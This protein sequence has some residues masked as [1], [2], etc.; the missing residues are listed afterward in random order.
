MISIATIAAA[1]LTLNPHA[2]DR[3]ADRIGSAIVAV[4]GDDLD[5]I[6]ALLVNGKAES[7][8]EADKGSCLVEGLGGLGFWGL[9]KGWGRREDRCGTVERQARIAIDAVANVSD[10]PA[11]HFAGYLARPVQDREVRVRT[12]LFWTVRARVELAACL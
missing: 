1:L 10:D 5:K 9:A 7:D 4:A 8:F 12:A 2:G 6:S 11:R 3:R